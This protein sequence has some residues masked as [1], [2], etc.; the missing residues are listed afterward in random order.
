MNSDPQGTRYYP[1]AQ[2]WQYVEIE[3]HESPAGKFRTIAAPT[4]GAEEP[5]PLAVVDKSSEFQKSTLSPKTVPPP[6]EKL[7]KLADHYG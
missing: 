2:E 7:S 6:G 4:A 3:L 1:Y 5:L